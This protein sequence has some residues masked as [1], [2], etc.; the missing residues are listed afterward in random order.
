M[1]F[2]TKSTTHN[3]YLRKK[4]LIT[5]NINLNRNSSSK[6]V[7][8]QNKINVEP[9]R[10]SSLIFDYDMTNN[11]GNGTFD[12]TISTIK[13]LAAN[14][15]LINLSGTTYEYD[16]L[17]GVKVKGGY[18]P[19]IPDYVEGA[20]TTSTI[21]FC[22]SIQSQWTTSTNELWCNIETGGET[23]RFIKLNNLPYF[24]YVPYVNGAYR[25]LSWRV[26]DNIPLVNHRFYISTTRDGSNLKIYSNGILVASVAQ[27]GAG[28][29]PNSSTRFHI[30]HNPAGT[31][32]ANATSQFTIY[33]L[34]HYTTALT[35]DQ[36]HNNYLY[37]NL[38]F[39]LDQQ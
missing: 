27:T 37:A 13:N 12:P 25:T 10:N 4:C 2:L 36:I 29:A 19:M 14:N 35:A 30:G 20:I 7:D 33:S 8:Y 6:R 11:T 26:P 18:S 17:C 23:F 34:R 32:R 5:P 9:I 39:K 1:R 22:F 3:D 31:T 15:N 21:E 28:K 24:Q 38:K 16:D